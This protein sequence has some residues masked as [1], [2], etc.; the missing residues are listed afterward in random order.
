MPRQLIF[1]PLKMDGWKTILSFGVSANFQGQKNVSFWEGK[2]Y[3]D[4]PLGSGRNLVL[5]MRELFPF[6]CKL[7]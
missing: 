3:K 1:S 5:F 6:G 2:Y 4:L 7:T